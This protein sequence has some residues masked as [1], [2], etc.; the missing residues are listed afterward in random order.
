MSYITKGL[1]NI[2]TFTAAL[3]IALATLVL[4]ILGL[5][6]FVVVTFTLWLFL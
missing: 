5:I 2:R 4:W 1:N 3:L 6:T